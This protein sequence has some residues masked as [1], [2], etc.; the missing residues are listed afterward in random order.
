LSA[1]ESTRALLALLTA[2]II[3]AVM[4]GGVW[5]VHFTE[6]GLVQDDV[7]SAV[8]ICGFLSFLVAPANL[9]YFGLKPA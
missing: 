4:V 6:A 9:Y 5:H 7:S 3:N 8:K 1:L 2:V